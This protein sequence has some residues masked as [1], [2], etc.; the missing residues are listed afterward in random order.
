MYFL[1]Y[2]KEDGVKLLIMK[3][4]LIPACLYWILSVEVHTIPPISISF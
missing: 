1:N 3:V 4:Y 2:E